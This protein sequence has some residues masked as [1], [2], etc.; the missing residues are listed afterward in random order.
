MSELH[1]ELKSVAGK[2]P[3]A[4]LPP[5]NPD[6]EKESTTVS[7]SE[8]ATTIT[9]PPE[10]A[11]DTPVPQF[12]APIRQEIQETHNSSTFAVLIFFFMALFFGLAYRRL[13]SVQ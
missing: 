5:T 7:Q 11:A 9:S 3:C 1:G 4:E 2:K 10:P 13:I 6:A 12:R 8:T